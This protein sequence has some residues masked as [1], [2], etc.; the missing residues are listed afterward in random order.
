MLEEGEITDATG[1]KI[2]LKHA[3]II[4]T[5]SF[6]ADE[7]KK[8]NFGFSADAPQAQSDAKRLREKLKERF[9]PELI[10]RLDQICLFNELT[11]NNLAQIAELEITALNTRLKKYRTAIAT[12]ESVL[13]KFIESMDNKSVNAR[14]IRRKIRVDI[15]KFLADI[16]TNGTP[17]KTY[18]LQIN[19]KEL[20]LK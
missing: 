7:L 5:T 20:S 16:I 15:E 11:P 13:Q 14:D 3:I 9:S 1:K 19:N 2:S 10:N 12:S 8:G 6:G 18:S 4:L 17:K